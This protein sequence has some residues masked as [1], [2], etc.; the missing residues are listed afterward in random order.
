VKLNND[1]SADCADIACKDEADWCESLFGGFC[2]EPAVESTCCAKCAQVRTNDA[3][4]YSIGDLQLF[5][6]FVNVI[7]PML[8]GMIRFVFGDIILSSLCV[9]VHAKCSLTGNALWL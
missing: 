4:M 8:A 9:S 1:F 2:Y 5:Q 6:F 3:S 7:A